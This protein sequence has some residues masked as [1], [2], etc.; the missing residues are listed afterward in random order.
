MNRSILIVT[1]DFLVLAAMSLSIGMSEVGDPAGAAK[2]SSPANRLV[3]MIDE[4]LARHEAVKQQK[5]ELEK[6]LEEF[7]ALALRDEKQIADRDEELE[8]AKA[9]LAET[10]AALTESKDALSSEKTRSQ[11]ELAKSAAELDKAKKELDEREAALKRSAA[12][13]AQKEK[14][15]D[16]SAKEIQARDKAIRENEAAIEKSEQALAQANKEKAE[17]AAKLAQADKEKAETAAK[18]AQADKEKAETAAKLAQADKE[19]AEAVAKLEQID[20]ESAGAVAKLEQVTKEKAETVAK[21]EQVSKEKA[22]TAA[23]LA[24]ADRGIIERDKVIRESEVLLEKSERS[25]AQVNKEKTETVEKLQQS[26]KSLSRT[27][28]QLETTQHELEA[29]REQARLDRARADEAVAKYHATEIELVETKSKLTS[30]QTQL[31]GMV[32][33]LTDVNSDLVKTKTDL[34]ES[35]QTLAVTKETLAQNE[36]ILDEKEKQIADKQRDLAETRKEAA[37]L[38]KMLNNDVLNSYNASALELS[39]HLVNDRLFNNITI[40][41]SFFLPAVT[42]GGKNWLVSAFR[43]TTG[44]N[45]YSGYTKVTELQYKVRRPQSKDKWTA[46]NGPALCLGEDSRV[47]LFPVE[48]GKAE[49]V[50]VL[51]FDALRERG[52]DNLTLFKS[53]IFSKASAD[54]TGRCSLSLDAGDNHLYIRNPNRSSTELKAEVGDFV[55]SKEGAFVGIVVKVGST[56]LSQASTA[57]CYVFTDEPDLSRALPLN[58]STTSS[59]GYSEFVNTHETLRKLVEQLDK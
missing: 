54:I 7:R 36:K 23:R 2:I 43:D 35:R 48:A 38:K 3:E 27:A 28:G 37:E 26:E 20:N 4:E 10:L 30:T 50:R 40:D 47:C 53:G 34:D 58:L 56:D 11:Q 15:L 33:V 12:V 41:K 29:L 45:L 32:R 5:D 17:T 22:E 39:F 16:L 31:D 46:I 59:Q 49:P 25:L 24:E 42:L 55:I 18:L 51:T 44:L 13:I 1:C 14:E 19:K 6:R 8:Q 21:L 52:V 9:K 57:I